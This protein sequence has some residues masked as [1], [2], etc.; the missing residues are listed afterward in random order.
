MEILG[1]GEDALTIW[2]I[3]NRLSSIL[4]TLKDSSTIPMCKV[5][6]RPSFG[7]SGGE[8]SSQFGEFDFIILSEQFLYLGESKWDRSSEQIRDG[9][10]ELRSE[11]MLRHDLFRFYVEEWGFGN[12]KSWSDF[13]REGKMKLEEKGIMKPLAPSGSLLASNLET[14]LRIIRKH[15]I[16]IPCI[17]NVLLYLHCKTDV[18]LLPRKAGKDFTV[19]AIDYSED[20]FDNFI[21]LKL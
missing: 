20:S 11:Q 17:H 18:N 15:Y 13:E 2:A 5:F 1:Y 4:Q 6:F 9:V 21:N 10:L 8:N 19:I 12:Y 3:K 16:A 14:V 7:R